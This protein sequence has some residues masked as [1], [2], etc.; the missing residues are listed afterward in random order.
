[1][2]VDY[3]RFRA[4]PWDERVTLFN[5]ISAAEKAELMRTH[6]TRWLESHRAELTPAQIALAEET[7]AF[8]TPELYRQPPADDVAARA[9]DFERRARELFTREQFFEAFTIQWGISCR[10]SAQ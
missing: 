2:S 5:A 9:R 10:R 7:L 8:A 1:M 3:E 4:M 6:V